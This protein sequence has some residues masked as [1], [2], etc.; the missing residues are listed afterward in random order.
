MGTRANTPSRP[1]SAIIKTMTTKKP[2]D[3]TEETAD[4]REHLWRA[5]AP[6]ALILCGG[7]CLWLLLD[8]P[9]FS[10]IPS[11]LSVL[12]VALLFIWVTAWAVSR[13]SAGEI[14]EK[15]WRKIVARSEFLATLPPP[16]AP[17]SAFNDLV[18]EAL[19]SLPPEFQKV[20]E[21]VPVVVSQ[22]GAERGAYGLYVGATVA[23][24][25]YP[26][27]IVIFEDTLVRDFGW[28]RESL[29]GQV[30]RVVCH[31]LAHHLGWNEAGVRNLGL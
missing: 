9:S 10:G 2:P 12:F 26:D 19:D 4:T 24:D 29:R 21:R 1:A 28:S 13:L 25:I 23:R 20:L 3:E 7:S 31:E 8:P 5:L 30:R 27:Y 6:V 15:R 22:G 18:Q 17:P 16:E 14:D 11:L